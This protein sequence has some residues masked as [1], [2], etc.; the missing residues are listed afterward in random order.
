MKTPSRL[1]LGGELRS[2]NRG[3]IDESGDRRFPSPVTLKSR[4][5][6]GHPNAALAGTPM[7]G[8]RCKRPGFACKFNADPKRASA[9]HQSR[10]M[11]SEALRE[12]RIRPNRESVC[13]PPS[14]ILVAAGPSLISKRPSRR[15]R[16]LRH[17]CGNHWSRRWSPRPGG[18]CHRAI[19]MNV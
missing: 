4:R 11:S 5:H 12:Y 14:E 16:D 8:P 1:S 3:A 18:P 13:L 7:F 17:C 19:R 10:P 15:S 9:G 6:H 2:W